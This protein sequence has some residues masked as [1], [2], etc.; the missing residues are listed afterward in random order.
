MN[1]RIVFENKPNKFTLLI[2][3]VQESDAGVYTLKVSNDVGDDISKANVS[4]E[5]SP[6]FIE[7]LKN[8]EILE[9]LLLILNCEIYGLPKP[10]IKW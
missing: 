6:V 9:N 8:S 1:S 2:H 7:P 10:E 4:V 5:V 3:S